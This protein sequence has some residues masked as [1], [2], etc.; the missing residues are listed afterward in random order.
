MN[1]RAYALV[2]QGKSDSS[3]EEMPQ[4]EVTRKSDPSG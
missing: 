3:S 1:D 4:W 2:D